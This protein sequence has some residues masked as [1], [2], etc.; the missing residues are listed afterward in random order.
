MSRAQAPR[1]CASCDETGCAMHRLHHVEAPVEGRSAWLLDEIWPETASMVAAT[2]GAEDQLLAPGLWGARPVRY[3]WPGPV[4]HAAGFAT[5][6]RHLAMR[7]VAKAPGG[8]RQRAYLAHDR[9]VAL[10]LARRIDH[11]C[12]HLVVAQTLLL[13]LDEAGALG[14]R[15]YDVLM[16]RHPLGEIHRRLDAAAAELGQSPTIGDFRADAALVERER[17]LLARARRIVTPHH[18]LA[19]MFPA[20][21]VRLAW[22]RPPPLPHVPG[23]RVAFLGPTI[24]RQRPDLVRALAAALPE[25]LIAFGAMLEGPDFWAGAA[26]ERR[27]FG[28]GWLDGIGAILHPATLTAQ[29]RRL[30]QAAASGVALY[31][32]AASGL[33]P[34]DYRPLAC[35]AVP[36]ATR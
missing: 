23:K 8:V 14:G 16:S 26:I 1:S 22:H 30:L 31:A 11:R 15:S 7:Q 3:A 33:D 29:P 2:R 6:G 36:E 18:E 10:A 9:Q 20:Q 4:R 5:L 17:A 32:T 35:F 27:T 19:A 13:W 34:A 25:P 12:S 24:A 21:A 28:P